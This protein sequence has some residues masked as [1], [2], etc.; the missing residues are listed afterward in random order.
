[1]RVF[2]DLSPGVRDGLADAALDPDAV[3]ALVRRA[4]AEDLGGGVDVTTVATIAPEQRSRASFGA[5]A[6]GVVAGITVARAVLEVVC[7]PGAVEAAPQRRDGDR[8]G[9]GDV[10]LEVT[11]PTAGL[12]TAER[13]AL[14]L[15][16]HLSGVATLTRRWADALQGTG[17]RVRDTRKTMPGMRA[18]QKYA[19]RCGGGVNHRMGL[20]DAALVKDNHVAAA[21]G[22]AQAFA[23]VGRRFPDVPREIEVDTLDG[24]REVLALGADLVLL[25][26]FTPAAMREAV[27]VRDAL[28]PTARLEASG[29]LTLEVAAE[30]GATGVDYIAVGELTHSARVLDLGLDFAPATEAAT[31]PDRRG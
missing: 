18:L 20:W 6:A 25:D 26:N 16:C 5:R 23:A 22:L 7:G 3:A 24:L 29:G 10:V 12:L 28:H 8:V 1:M 21:G 15:L 30:V 31:T 19:V 2:H 27:A 13:T 14:N 17:A 11:A 9:R 4:V